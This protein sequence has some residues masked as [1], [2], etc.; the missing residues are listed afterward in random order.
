MKKFISL[1]IVIGLMLMTAGVAPAV[2]W[3]ISYE[4]AGN[5]SGDYNGTPFTNSAF[6]LQV[7][8]DTSNVV[9]V[10]WFDTNDLYGVGNYPFL[11]AGPDLSG[12]LAV[13]GVG[14]FTFA[15]RLWARA[16][17]AN[18]LN[19]GYFALGTDVE[20]VLIEVQDPFFETYHLLT[21]AKPLPVSLWQVGAV[22]FAVS[23]SSGTTGELTLTDA[24]SLM[25]QAEGGVPEP[26]TF[27]L[28]GAGLAGLMIM[29]RRRMK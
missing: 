18:F 24:S 5:L 8:A 21:A 2:Q 11:F 16:T 19:P 22:P 9:A 10:S 26:S 3:P 13:S 14:T 25:F 15:N 20:D 28:L 27:V 17:Q 29:R 4:L 6:T 23:D 7:V 12:S 1:L